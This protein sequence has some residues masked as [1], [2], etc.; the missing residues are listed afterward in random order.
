[1]PT[2]DGRREFLRVMA[3]VF[4][5]NWGIRE[6]EPHGDALFPKEKARVIALLLEKVTVNAVSIKVVAA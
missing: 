6:F 3:P 1:M 2:L 4:G 5:G